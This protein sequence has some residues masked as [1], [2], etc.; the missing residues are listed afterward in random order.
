MHLHTCC[1]IKPGIQC[2]HGP[3]AAGCYVFDAK[4]KADMCPYMPNA[5]PTCCCQASSHRQAASAALLLL[6]LQEVTSAA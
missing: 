6:W 4:V 1:I 3:T 2:L 5:R